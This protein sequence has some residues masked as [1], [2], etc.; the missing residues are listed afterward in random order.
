[1][2][3]T[4]N[5]GEKLRQLRQDRDLTQPELAEAM[6]IEQ[7]YLS[8]LENGKYVP[9]GDVF[10]RIREVFK[11][12]VGDLVDD[13]DAG[14]RNQLR[15]IP[16]VA[17]HFDKQKEMMIGNRR[18]WLLA[19]A[20]LIAVG[21]GLVYG[22]SVDLLVS[23][24]SYQYKSHG[25][26]RAGESKEFFSILDRSYAGDPSEE[27]LAAEARRDEDF[28]STGRFQGDVFNVPA[29]GGSRTYYLYGTTDLDP[30]ANR[31]VAFFGVM[32]IAFGVTGLALEKK[33]SLYQ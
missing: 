13:L 32:M 31:L 27:R 22:G 12:Q 5:L 19:S 26:V 11:L 17:R 21:S 8:K 28:M 16:E 6:G 30:I 1:M 3:L 7:S 2:E 10:G 18:R 24:T 9:S 25:I 20:I 29:P 33:L 15:Q 14:A 4:M 23:D